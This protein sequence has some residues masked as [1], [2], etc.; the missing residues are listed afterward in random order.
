MLHIRRDRALLGAWLALL[1]ACGSAE[2]EGGGDERGCSDFENN[3]GASFRCNDDPDTTDGDTDTGSDTDPTGDECELG[4]NEPPSS[5]EPQTIVLIN[6]GD[7][8][9]YT[10]GGWCSPERF[11]FT[12]DG[13]AYSQNSHS[14][15][16]CEVMID[17]GFCGPFQGCKDGDGGVEP[18]VIGPGESYEL[19][20]TGDLWA[21][22]E[23]PEGC[24]SEECV[25]GITCEARRQV[26]A[27]AAVKITVEAF[28]DCQQYGGPCACLD[29]AT[30]CALNFNEEPPQVGGEPSVVEVEFSYPAT[31]PIEIHI[32]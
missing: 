28:P 32:P 23:L 9:V 1:P 18:L 15:E 19:T 7:A 5:N 25:G 22:V 8:P 30:T 4:M 29:D 17:N 13:L 21:E 3:E 27:G 11:G 20:W 2:D 14:M 10:R 24:A 26:A 31:G 12:V 16:S 6:D